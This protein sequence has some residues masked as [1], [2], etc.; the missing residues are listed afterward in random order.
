MR[1]CYISAANPKFA[2]SVKEAVSRHGGAKEK[3][4]VLHIR[5]TGL[6][7]RGVGGVAVGF[8]DFKLVKKDAS[9]PPEETEEVVRTGLLKQI[10]HGGKASTLLTN[11]ADALDAARKGNAPT[12]R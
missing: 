8:L 11:G 6:M 2:A 4:Y 12:C 9:P 5:I 1:R 10:T 7:Q 3:V